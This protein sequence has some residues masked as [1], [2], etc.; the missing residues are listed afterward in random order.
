MHHLT[1][2]A[3]VV[4]GSGLVGGALLRALGAHAIG[5]YR[6]RPVDGLRDLDARDAASVRALVRE[7][8]PAVVFFPAAEPNVDWCE[9]H[10]DEARA[11]NVVPALAALAAARESGASFVFFSTDYVFDGQDGPYDET[12]DVRPLGVYGAHKAEVEE[13][14]LDA[15]CTVVR[16]TTVF[17]TELPPGKNFVVR[18]V[19]RLRAGEVTTIPSDQLATPTWSD[20]LARASLG[21]AHD[22]GVWH[23]AGPDLMSRDEFA[24][25]VARTFDCDESLIHPVTTDQLHQPTR[26]PLRAGL[27]T[28]KIQRAKMITFTPVAEALRHLPVTPV[29]EL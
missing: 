11:A 3:L 5:T 2:T 25:L 28:E 23:A 13:R 4:G 10:P 19:A 12:A 7:L 18:L 14:V 22:P 15:G 1:V 27:R 16:T 26:R 8:D 20:D 9:L 29:S 6:T 21:V 17:G 24:R